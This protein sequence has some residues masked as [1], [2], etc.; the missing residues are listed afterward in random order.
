[1]RTGAV[2]LIVGLIFLLNY[3]REHFFIPPEM[4]VGGVALFGMGLL[5]LGWTLRVR[6]T[7]YA[8]SLQGAGIAT[9]YVTISAALHLYGLIAPEA[10]FVLLAAMAAFSAIIAVRQ[11]SLA[12]ALIGLLGGL[13]APILA[14][15]G[16]ANHVALFSYYLALN[17]GVVTIAW[18]KAWRSLN[19]LAFVSTFL[20]GAAWASAT[21]G[22]SI[23][24]APSSS[25][26]RSSCSTWSSRSSSPALHRG[27]IA[28]GAFVDGT[29]V[30]GN[31]IAAF[32]LQAGL[33]KGT[34][35]GLA[36]SSLAIA[37]I[38]L[39]L[40]TFLHRQR[41]E[42]WALLSET[43]LALGVVFA[44][45]A[46]PLALDARWT[47]AAW[48]LEGAAIFWVGVRQQRKL[49]R[50]FGL[51]LQLLAGLAYVGPYSRMPAGPPLADAP[52]IGALLIAFAGL[53]THR[54]VAAGGERVTQIE[55]KAAP[56]LLVWGLAWW[57]VAGH[58]EIRTFLP[59][60]FR[61]NAHA[62]FFAASA[63][64]FA[65][66][67]RKLRWSG[68]RWPAFVLLPALAVVAFLEFARH[69]HPFADYGWLA[70]TFAI[71]VQVFLLRDLDAR[72]DERSEAEPALHA[73]TFLLVAVLGAW[74]MHWCAVQVTA[75]GTSWSVASTLLVPAMLLL[76][77]VSK[78]MDAR[79]PITRH[80][81]AY[82]LGAVC[83]TLVAMALW[84]L[85]ANA[86][87]DGTSTPL[88][89]L[90]ILNAIDLGHGL[91]AI[92]VMGAILAWRRSGL[93]P[94]EAFRGQTG[95]IFVAAL[96]FIWLNGMLLRSVHHWADV[97]YRLPAMMRSF[98]A[99]AAISIFWSLIALTLMVFATRRGNR[100]LWMIGGALM[101]VVV[102]KLFVIDLSNLKG[103]ERIVSFI[104]V[105]LLML[106]IGYFSPVPPRKKEETAKV[107]EPA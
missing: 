33:M 38:Y 45:L 14:S 54:L 9:L 40:A 8:V 74:E 101:G 21:T 4:R 76:A 103:L 51:L 22:R 41:S 81:G 16:S 43:F 55:G 102:V 82:R 61:L 15:T 20:V 84:I 91:I 53:W 96:A 19:I 57:F 30:F 2:V 26:S 13:L 12:L 75:G 92:C 85:Y 67:A 25:W 79:W 60:E 1:V 80:A 58:H 44:T 78:E 34:E 52:F 95:W 36:Y 105:G 17:L 88:P 98:V 97:P 99:Q 66:L 18:F 106:V 62:A 46:I 47:S 24:P 93:E 5:V 104:V 72:D 100:T 35:F 37:A 68:T 94:P 50:A 69:T 71:A 89:Y 11:D 63:L 31:P 107:E 65:L 86:T 32:G 23:S 77:V 70:W 49:A 29:I 28:G 90:P 59:T 64:A 3:A 7:G 39:T 10:A 56:A 42:R 48:A 27:R 6:R 83:A 87:H 73:G